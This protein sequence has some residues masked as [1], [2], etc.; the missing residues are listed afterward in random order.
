MISVLECK[1]YGVFTDVFSTQSMTERY[2][3]VAHERGVEG[4]QLPYLLIDE[5]QETEGFRHVRDILS[6][7]SPY[8]EV[9]RSKNYVLLKPNG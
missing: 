4:K 1:P 5:S 6:A 3:Y 8:E 9:W 2:L 7:M